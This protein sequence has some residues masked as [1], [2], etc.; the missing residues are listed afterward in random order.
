MFIGSAI[1]GKPIKGKNGQ[2]AGRSCRF[3]RLRSAAARLRFVYL[4]RFTILELFF[5]AFI[6][7]G[8][9]SKITTNA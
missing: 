8:N 1:D 7:I 9:R 5:F 3:L 4:E 6:P 2:L